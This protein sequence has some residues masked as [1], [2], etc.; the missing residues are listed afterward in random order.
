MKTP[1]STEKKN[2]FI[3]SILHFL[4]VSAEKKETKD[5]KNPQKRAIEVP[6]IEEDFRFITS[7]FYVTSFWGKFC[8]FHHSFILISFMSAF[9]FIQ[10]FL[11]AR[12]NDCRCR[13]RIVYIFVWYALLF[14]F[15]VWNVT[16][17]TRVLKKT[18][19]CI[20]YMRI[21]WFLSRIWHFW[22]VWICVC[23]EY[24]HW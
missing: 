1:E 8:F 10:F 11:C 14:V 9:T 15:F 3:S 20:L 4:P 16:I 6:L 22:M 7:E 13:C 21:V 17:G 19:V 24:D 12:Y 2:F 18:F 5:E 23:F